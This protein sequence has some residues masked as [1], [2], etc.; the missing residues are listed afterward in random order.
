MKPS[1]FVYIIEN[2]GIC[3]LKLVVYERSKW[4][5]NNSKIALH[6]SQQID[7]QVNVNKTKYKL[8]LRLFHQI[9]LG[10]SNKSSNMVS[11]HREKRNVTVLVQNLKLRS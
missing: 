11:K 7:P 3:A 5:K 1:L 8:P 10:L 2:I 6:V 4:H 9:L